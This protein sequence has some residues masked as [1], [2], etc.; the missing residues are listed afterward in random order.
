MHN[1]EGEREDIVR[2]GQ[3][4]SGRSDN[5]NDHN[6]FLF[7]CRVKHLEKTLPSIGKLFLLN[8]M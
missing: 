6:D 1:V 4:E 5:M 7:H 2:E 8:K 3:S